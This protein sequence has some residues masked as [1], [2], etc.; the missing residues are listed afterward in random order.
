MAPDR[1]QEIKGGLER[2][3]ERLRGEGASSGELSNSL[4]IQI[5]SDLGISNARNVDAE[6]Q[7]L[8]LSRKLDRVIERQEKL[9]N[10]AERLEALEK[11]EDLNTQ[12]RQ[13]FIGA[14]ILGKILWLLFGGG[15]VW[16]LTHLPWKQ[17]Q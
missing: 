2:S 5:L 4:L 7:R 8:D 15:I 12:F 14:G 9:T 17:L 10:V 13:Q 6:R 11:Q 3:I 16:I 1:E